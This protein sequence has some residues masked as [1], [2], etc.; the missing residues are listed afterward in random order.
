LDFTFED[1]TSTEVHLK[2]QSVPCS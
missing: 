2:N 1:E